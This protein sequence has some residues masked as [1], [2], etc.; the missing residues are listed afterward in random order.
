M[1]SKRSNVPVNGSKQYY[2]NVT[3]K[4]QEKS[5]LRSDA[6]IWSQ[7]N[8]SVD[9]KDLTYNPF[10]ETVPVYFRDAMDAIFGIP[11][12]GSIAYMGGG[13]LKPR[14]AWAPS[15]RGASALIGK[16]GD[17]MPIS[18]AVESGG[19]RDGDFARILINGID[20]SPNEKGF[21]IVILNPQDMD[22]YVGCFDT[23]SHTSNESQHLVNFLEQISP[24]HIVLIAVRGDAA[25]RLHQSARKAL[26]NIGLILPKSD[27]HIR[28]GKLVGTLT[29]SKSADLLQMCSVVNA[30]KCTEILLSGGWDINYCKMH[31]SHNT[32]LIDAVFFGSFDVVR[33]LLQYKANTQLVNKWGESALDVAKKL[34]GVDNLEA[35][36]KL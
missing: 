12:G 17:K 9:D 21:N 23:H 6:Q 13:D 22:A 16:Y 8:S 19:F 33:V 36:L 34:Y 1:K 27:D 26:E 15:G 2:V 20:Y 18:L 5:S 3:K 32:A 11:F 4:P 28:L 25:R 14:T 31:G 29:I 30:P 7:R 24:S 10:D 35:L